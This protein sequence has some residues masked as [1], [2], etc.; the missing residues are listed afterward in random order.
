M[1]KHLAICHPVKYEKSEKK[2]AFNQI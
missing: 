2:W 1:S